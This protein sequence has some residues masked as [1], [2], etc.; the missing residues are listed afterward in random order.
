MPTPT[1]PT[2]AAWPPVAPNGVINA[3]LVYDDQAMT[4]QVTNSLG[5]ATTFTWDDDQLL[6]RSDAL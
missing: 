5:Q 3:T 6:D 2:G 4:T 1:H